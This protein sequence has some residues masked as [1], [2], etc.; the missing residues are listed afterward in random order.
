MRNSKKTSR[1][2]SLP[3]EQFQF[4]LDNSNSFTG[5]LEKLNFQTRN[6]NSRETIKKRIAQDS[7]DTTKFEFNKKQVQQNNSAI[8]RLRNKIPSVECFCQNSK[9]TRNVIKS[10]LKNDYLIPY[11]CEICKNPGMHNDIPLVLQLDHKNGIN[12]DNRLENLRFLCPNCHTQ[13]DTYAN[14]KRI[15]K[16][17][18]ICGSKVKDK[19]A[20][21]CKKCHMIFLRSSSL[22]QK[23]K[24][25]WPEPTV[26]QTLLWKQPTSSIAKQLG[27]SD[28]AI[29]KFCKKHKLSKPSRGFWQKLANGKD[30]GHII[31]DD[32]GQGGG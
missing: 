27:V 5:I 13:T 7:L 10:R 30:V 29:R 25:T 1:I 16:K 23:T 8:L 20:N 22:S 12:N 21:K 26:L 19:S 14:K 17:C 24:I 2:W 9:V 15:T 31:P 3:K 4:L 28:V 18:S 6:G 11:E 32:I